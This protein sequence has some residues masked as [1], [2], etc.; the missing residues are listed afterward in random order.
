MLYLVPHQNAAFYLAHEV[1]HQLGLRHQI[2]TPCFTSSYMSV[3]TRSHTVSYEQ[4]RWTRCE[5][6]WI[7]EH[8]CQFTCLFNQPDGY[9]P[10]KSKY[11][12]L[13][14]QRMNN[15]QQAKMIEQ[16]DKALGESGS[17]SFMPSDSQ[18]RCLYL[19]Y[20]TGADKTGKRL[21]LPHITEL[22]SF[23]TYVRLHSNVTRLRLRAEFDMLSRSMRS[24][25]HDRCFVVQ[26]RQ[27][28]QHSSSEWPLQLRPSATRIE[29]E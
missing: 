28:H 6:D 14:G 2:D 9:Q 15:E 25:G 24:K 12:T 16:N 26:C 4:A 7:N 29:D 8:I 21:L 1:G 3:M 11:S 13:P 18:S 17:L 20:Y 10:I 27:G 22:D 19:T 23:S 5:N